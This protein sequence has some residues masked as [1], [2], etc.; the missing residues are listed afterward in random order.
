GKPVR[1]QGVNYSG[2]EYACVG[3]TGK[4]GY[5]V[6]DGPADQALVDGF[7]SWNVRAVRIPLNETCWLGING[8]TPA[9]SGANYQA[10][11]AR[12][13]KLLT[14]NGI[15]AIVDLHWNAPGNHIAMGQ[16]KMAD[17]DHSPG[18]WYQVANTFKANPAVVFDL[19]NEPRFQTAEDWIC[20]RSGGCSVTKVDS[21]ETF[22][23]A[24]MQEMIDAVRWS[25]AKNAI[26]LSG[27][28]W[29]N[30]LGLWTEN[31]PT[32][33]SNQLAAGFHNYNDNFCNNV[34]CW[35]KKVADT[36]AGV[37]VVTTELGES[38]CAHTF[39]DAYMAWADPLNIS[40]VGWSW[41]PHGC[42]DQPALVTDYAGTPTA[43]GVGLRDH[44]RS[45]PQARTRADR[46]PE[47]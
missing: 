19:Y 16:Q 33:L 28:N 3:S 35:N 27:I 26:I 10:E 44:L 38:D 21:T 5:G 8:V 14:D 18:F 2:A 20:W 32:D 25:G 29:G 24:G 39:I 37:P 36:A 31:K 47:A 30:D 12:F 6:W 4:N 17:R 11:I 7:K 41:N 22:V 43:Y 15:Y 42:S 1:L 46:Q 40:Y 9:Y 13:V 45:F 23:A 34:T